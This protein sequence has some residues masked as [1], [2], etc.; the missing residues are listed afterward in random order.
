MSFSFKS[1]EQEFEKLLGILGSTVE[2]DPNAQAA[3]TSTKQAITDAKTSVVTAA[4]PLVTSA[5]VKE[6]TPTLGAEGATIA[7]QLASDAI[8]AGASQIIAKL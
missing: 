3:V 1:I 5:I 6:L 2:A 8:V 7:G 4:T